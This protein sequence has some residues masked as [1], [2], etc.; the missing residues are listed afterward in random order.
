MRRSIVLLFVPNVLHRVYVNGSTRVEAT[1][2]VTRVCPPNAQECD[3][4]GVS[5]NFLVSTGDVTQKPVGRES[6]VVERTASWV[7]SIRV[8]PHGGEPQ[9]G[10]IGDLAYR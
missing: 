6:R 8:A 3:G 2:T 4:V 1:F 9:R 5:A 7:A 10:Q